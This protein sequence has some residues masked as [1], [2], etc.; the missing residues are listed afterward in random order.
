MKRDHSH[1]FPSS[2]LHFPLV[3]RP[4]SHRANREPIT[5]IIH[6]E[7]PVIRGG[8]LRAAINHSTST[9]DLFY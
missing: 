5:N 3:A 7:P 4:G 8:L 6:I 2:I 9:D 1:S